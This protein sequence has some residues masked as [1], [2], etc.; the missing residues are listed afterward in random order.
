MQLQKLLGLSSLVLLGN[1]VGSFADLE[2]NEIPKQ[3][4]PI[5]EPIVQRSDQC[6]RKTPSD[7]AEMECICKLDN[8]SKL[9]PL[10]EACVAKYHAIVSDDNNLHDNGM[11]A[12]DA[13]IT[14]NG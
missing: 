1:V 7:Y 5:C 14:P 13:T 2:A 10:C 3:C 6:D 9:I 11:L 12:V 4:K 8:A